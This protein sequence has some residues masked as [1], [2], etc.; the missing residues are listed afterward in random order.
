MR[1]I[2]LLSVVVAIIALVG[3]EALPVRDLVVPD[4]TPEKM[5]SEAMERV[6][7]RRSEEVAKAEKS[8]DFSSIPQ[9]FEKILVEELEL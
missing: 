7:K 5:A 6:W 8:G 2:L 9:V 1:E 3:C 4:I